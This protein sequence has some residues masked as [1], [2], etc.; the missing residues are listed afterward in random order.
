MPK[1]AIAVLAAGQAA[2]F[3]SPKQLACLAD[4]RTLLQ[5]AVDVAY[6]AIREPPF[7]ILGAYA[8]IIRPVINHARLIDNSQWQQG[9][10]SSIA[11]ATR[12]IGEMDYAGVLFLLADQVALAADDLR[13][14]IARFSSDHIVC[15][16]YSDL[17]E[18]AVLGVPAMFPRS[19]FA[20]LKNLR[21]GQGAKILLDGH[22]LP[23]VSVD[24]PA[25]KIDI[26]TVPA[27]ADFNRGCK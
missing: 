6:A 21:G 23:V 16:N 1:I 12:V 19:C 20:Q 10:G 13:Q 15:A 27:L 24:L 9:M 7:V 26:D 22:V 25:A 14:M 3:G 4:G 8:E 17:S 2:R 11:C 5:H 18:A